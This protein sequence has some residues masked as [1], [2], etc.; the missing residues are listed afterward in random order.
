MSGDAPFRVLRIEDVPALPAPWGPHVA[1]HPVR[2]HL[3]LRAFGINAYTAE[4]AGAELVEEHDETGGSAGGHE[5]IY[6][7]LSGRVRFTVD[8]DDF[9]AGPGTFLAARD[10]AVRRK[11]V[12]LEDGATVLAIGAPIGAAYEVAPWEYVFRAHGASKQGSPADAIPIIEQGLAQ[13][14]DHAALL[15]QLACYE[16]LSGLPDAAL[17]H[18]QRAVARDARFARHAATDEDLDGIREMPGFPTA[19]GIAD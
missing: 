4:T 19:R 7:V 13:H 8:G 6:V 1:W 9:E 16:A 15:Y 5:E 14:P 17:E 12:A 2:F 10:P 3:G 18:L 11:A